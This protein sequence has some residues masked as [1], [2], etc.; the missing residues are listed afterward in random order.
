VKEDLVVVRFEDQE[1]TIGQSV[2]DLSRGPSQ[3]GGYPQAETGA[4]VDQRYP[5]WVRRVMHGEEGF[6]P[7]VP[8]EEGSSWPVLDDRLFSP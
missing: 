1:V 8:D 6:H 3:V 4:F 7:E 5:D 2:A